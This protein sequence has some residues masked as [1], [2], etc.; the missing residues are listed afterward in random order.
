ML[1][2]PTTC[3]SPSAKAGIS[4]QLLPAKA[5]LNLPLLLLLLRLL[6]WHA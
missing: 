3:K 1:G 6:G 4:A 2:K 5:L